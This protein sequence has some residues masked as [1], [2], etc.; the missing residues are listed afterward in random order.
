[1]KHYCTIEGNFYICNIVTKNLSETSTIRSII[2]GFLLL[3]FALG[4]TPKL[5]LHNLIATHKDGSSA[6]KKNGQ[7]A[8]G[9]YAFNCQ[10]ENQVIESP[11]MANLDC[12]VLSNTQFFT[13]FENDFTE[14]YL[15]QHLFGFT[16]RGPPTVA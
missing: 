8:V 7:T 3:V 12:F 13:S 4:I 9:K 16:L 11:F 5:T 2:T 1:M 14:N 10:C 15:A 6:V